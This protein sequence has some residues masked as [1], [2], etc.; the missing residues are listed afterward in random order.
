MCG[1]WKLE[2]N[3]VIGSAASVTWLFQLLRSVLEGRAMDVIFY[4]IDLTKNSDV[5]LAFEALKVQMNKTFSSL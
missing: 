2:C 1:V 5:R 4:Y 3:C